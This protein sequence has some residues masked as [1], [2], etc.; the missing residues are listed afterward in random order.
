[1]L[2]VIIPNTKLG[3][4][5]GFFSHGTT[6]ILDRTGLCMG[7]SVRWRTF[8]RMAGLYPLDASTTAPCI[9]PKCVQALPKLYL[10]IAKCALGAKLTPAE[11]HSIQ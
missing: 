8:S 7:L 10:D 3:Y 5:V 11:S 1:M 4:K 6:D 9:P 2:I